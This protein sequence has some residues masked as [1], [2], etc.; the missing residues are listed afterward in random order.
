MRY[1]L[2]RRDGV[3]QAPAWWNV[4]GTA[5]HEC[6]REWETDQAGYP[7]D[8]AGRTP[9]AQAERFG[10]H[11]AN[12]IA[13]TVL[14]TGIGP[15]GWRTGGRASTQ[16]PNKEDRAWWLD[17][18]PEMVAKYVQAQE[19]RDC[20]VLRLGE[21]GETLALELGFLWQ[22]ALG[23]LPPV[24]GFIDQVLYY[25]RTDAILI[26]DYKS[27]SSIPVD[28]LQV[29]IYRLALEQVFGIKASKW[30]GDYW[31]ARKGAASRGWDLTDSAKVEAGVR[32][33]LHAMDMAENLN[34]YP[35]NP[36]NNCSACG[37]RAA[38]PAM[39]DEPFALWKHG[40]R[41]GKPEPLTLAPLS[42]GE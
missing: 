40:E 31:Q 27:G 41:Y 22:P 21:Q 42:T 39:S 28:S 6:I 25:P 20:E 19:G 11:L 35:P 24:K 12:A 15:S 3:T 8:S 37:V 4:A 13:E 1:R 7:H 30:W 36:G 29:G 16:Y 26:R 23:E 32:Y 14:A 33:R 2:E 17:N 5:F 10:H 34:L 18:G 38:C 9:D